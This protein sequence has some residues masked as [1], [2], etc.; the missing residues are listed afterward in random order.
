[1]R[2]NLTK[3]SF[4]AMYVQRN[5]SKS[6][7]T[8]RTMLQS[9]NWIERAVEKPFSEI[10]HADFKGVEFMAKMGEIHSVNTQ[11]ATLVALIKYLEAF[12]KPRLVKWYQRKLSDLVCS[13][14]STQNAQEKT[15]KEKENWI[16]YPTLKSKIEELAT[17]DFLGGKQTMFVAL[18]NFTLMAIYTLQPPARI[19]NFLGMVKRHQNKI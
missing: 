3:E 15:E 1:M 9:L 17:A 5:K 18:R 2:V 4:S 8:R 16:D 10:G 11:V 7:A 14:N 13:R 6:E 12:K 19:S